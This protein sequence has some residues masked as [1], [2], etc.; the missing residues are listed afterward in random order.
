[1]Q[2]RREGASLIVTIQSP[3]LRHSDTRLAKLDLPL[4]RRIGLFDR[5]PWL[6]FGSVRTQAPQPPSESDS[7]A[8][9]EPLAT[10]VES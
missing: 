1:M 7:M 8:S 2:A 10:M 5:W 3:A 6:S 4:R 9:K